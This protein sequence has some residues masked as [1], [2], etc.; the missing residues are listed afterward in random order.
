MPHH[1]RDPKSAGFTLIEL[2]VVMAIISILAGLLLPSLTKAR[3]AARV[4][5]CKNQERQVLIALIM[6]ADQNDGKIPTASQTGVYTGNSQAFLRE[7]PSKNGY[8]PLVGLGK[9]GLIE[10]HGAKFGRNIL[11]D[12]G[13]FGCSAS[14]GRTPTDIRYKW[15]RPVESGSI[16]GAFLYRETAAGMQEK[17]DSSTGRPKAI[18]IDNSYSYGGKEYIPH[19]GDTVNIAFWDGHV[20]TVN[21]IDGRF[22]RKVWGKEE[23]VRLWKAADEE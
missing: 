3:Q 8:S 2:L 14:R 19:N 18:I 22:T 12:A 5:D 1:T 13:I 10:Y 6:A 21:N 7:T 15:A 9:L 23:D 16:E 4:T 17:P 20:K 11:T